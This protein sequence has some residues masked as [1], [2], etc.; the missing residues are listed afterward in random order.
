MRAGGVRGKKIGVLGLGIS[1]IGSYMSLREGGADVIVW[2]ES[3]NSRANFLN[4]MLYKFNRPSVENSIVDIDSN[5][6]HDLEFIIF[7]P[8]IPTHFPHPHK[9]VEIAKKHNIK[10]I[11]DIEVMSQSDPYNDIIAITGTNGKSTVTMLT[12][13]ILKTAE[14]PM[15]VGGNIGAAALSLNRLRVGGKYVIECSSYQLELMENFKP[16]VAVLLNLSINHTD[17]YKNFDDYIEAK[18]NIFYN[19]NQADYVIINYDN[20]ITREIYYRLLSSKK[21]KKVIPFSVES[22]LKNGGYI[23]NGKLFYDKNLSFKLPANWFLKGKHNEENI[24]ASVIA[25]HCVGVNAEK[26]FTQAIET[27][28]GLKHRME[29]LGAKKGVVYINDSKATNMIA[30]QK[31]LTSFKDIAWIAGG[32]AKG[33]ADFSLLENNLGNVKKAFLIGESADK[34]ALF[35]DQHKISYKKCDTL[36]KAF[37]EATNYSLGKGIVLLSP[38]FPSFDQ[39]KNFA[40]RGEIFRKFYNKL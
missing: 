17:R 40:E 35:L 32:S 20:N 3:P 37:E 4:K 9:L 38:G 36:K 5:L 31:A 8:G 21:F 24:L 23:K 14:I 34:I 19:Q 22:E 33:E 29:Y 39:F 12:S 7:S 11:C 27:F 18:L 16:K 25:A 26:I 15:E 6:W 13:H 1:G 2:D 28:I 10:I 30:V